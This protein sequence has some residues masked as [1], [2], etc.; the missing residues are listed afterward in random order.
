MLRIVSADLQSAAADTLRARSLLGGSIGGGSVII[1]EEWLVT[2]TSFWN[3]TLRRYCVLERGVRRMRPS[4]S[5][6]EGVMAR[7]MARASSSPFSLGFLAPFVGLEFFDV[8]VEDGG[9]SVSS[10]VVL[11]FCLVGLFIFFSFKGCL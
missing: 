8:D 3:S 7:A 6:P 1:D 9:S 11:S 2:L 10:S 5:K 4:S